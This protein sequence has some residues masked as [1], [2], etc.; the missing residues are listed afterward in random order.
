[1][2]FYIFEHPETQERV[3]V[4]QRMKDA[5]EYIDA[6]GLKWDRVF[7]SNNMAIDSRPDAFSKSALTNSTSNKKETIGDLQDRAK[8][9][10]EKRKEKDGYDTMQNQWFSDYS[11]RRKGQKHP[12]DPSAGGGTL[13]I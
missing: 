1:M 10:S 4:R 2:P 13:E 11:K 3:E 5:H 7:L 6:N 12:D 8:E 9:A